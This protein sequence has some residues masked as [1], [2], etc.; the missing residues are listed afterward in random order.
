MI[1]RTLLQKYIYQPSLFHHGT[2]SRGQ[3]QDEDIDLIVIAMGPTFLSSDDDRTTLY[4]HVRKLNL[5]FI[6]L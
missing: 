1:M 5:I 3:A 4:D 2:D 6:L